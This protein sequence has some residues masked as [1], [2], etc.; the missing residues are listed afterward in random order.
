MTFERSRCNVKGKVWSSSYLNHAECI[1]CSQWQQVTWLKTISLKNGSEA[2]PLKD[3]VAP[4]P[5]HSRSIVFAKSCA[6][7]VHKLCKFSARST[8]WFC[9]YF[10]IN[11]CGFAS[12][13]HGRWLK[14]TD[15]FRFHLGRYLGDLESPGVRRHSGGGHHLR[16]RERHQPVR[17]GRVLLRRSGGAAAGP[18][19][20]EAGLA[21]NRLHRHHQGLLG[22]PVRGGC[23]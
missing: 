13:L 22:E 9:G 3:V 8:Q 23:L 11:H 15:S 18:D 10:R 14:S 17:H 4:C 6:K 1:H 7:D 16:L 5:K 19:P 2:V 20:E 21:E 12:P